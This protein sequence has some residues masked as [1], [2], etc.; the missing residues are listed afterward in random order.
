MLCQTNLPR[1]L[2]AEQSK[3]HDFVDLDCGGRNLCVSD[4][5]GDYGQQHDNAKI[6]CLLVEPLT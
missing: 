5:L 3:A 4:M 2:T 6:Q 1:I